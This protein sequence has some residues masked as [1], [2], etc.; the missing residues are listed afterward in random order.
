MGYAARVGTLC[1]IAFLVNCKPSEPYL[2][3]STLPLSPGLSH[4]WC[5]AG[6]LSLPRSQSST[7]YTRIAVLTPS[8]VLSYR[9]GGVGFLRSRRAYCATRS[10]HTCMCIR[11][12]T[13]PP[14]SAVG[15]P[16]T[17]T[18][19]PTPKQVPGGGEGLERRAAGGV[20]VA[21]VHVRRV[22]VRAAAGAAGGELGVLQRSKSCES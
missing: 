13:I 17:L 15:W 3:R 9:C 18:W 12:R 5:L 7:L 10:V 14:R 11:L 8:P 19:N 1:A 2:T 6:R 22:G 4:A 16:H 21:V 20:G